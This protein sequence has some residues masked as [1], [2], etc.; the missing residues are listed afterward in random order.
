[1][2]RLVIWNV[3]TMLLAQS[4]NFISFCLSNLFVFMLLTATS[5]LKFRLWFFSAFFGIGVIFENCSFV[6]DQLRISDS[7][8]EILI[9][10]IFIKIFLEPS[11]ST[12]YHELLGDHNDSFTFNYFLY[13]AFLQ[14][15]QLNCYDKSN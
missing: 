10:G 6:I 14:H 15:V 5:M 12:Q 11:T 13:L 3:Q 9:C 4:F 1:M 2:S 7:Q 8:R